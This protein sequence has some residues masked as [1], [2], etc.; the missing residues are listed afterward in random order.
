METFDQ[1]SWVLILAFAACYLYAISRLIK[2][3]FEDG[4]ARGVPGWLLS[5]AFLATGPMAW[6]LW[7][8]FRPPVKDDSNADDKFDINDFR[9]Q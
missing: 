4:E 7:L 1:F 3:A 2:F 8:L 6:M 5:L 9:V